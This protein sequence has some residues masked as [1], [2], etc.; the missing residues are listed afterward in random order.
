M[1]MN[2]W[3]GAMLASVI[4]VT[5]CQS[6]AERTQLNIV[7]AVPFN[8][9]NAEHIIV[10]TSRT[11]LHEEPL[12]GNREYLDQVYFTTALQMAQLAGDPQFM[13]MPITLTPEL[14]NGDAGG[15]FIALDTPWLVSKG[16]L[17]HEE[18]EVAVLSTNNL[19]NSHTSKTMDLAAYNRMIANAI[20]LAGI[21]NPEKTDKQ[22]QLEIGSLQ[23]RR[24]FYGYSDNVEQNLNELT[25]VIFGKRGMLDR[26]N[27][28]DYSGPNADTYHNTSRLAFFLPRDKAQAQTMLNKIYTIVFMPDA[29]FE[30]KKTGQLVVLA[31]GREGSLL[32]ENGQR[33]AGIANPSYFYHDDM[34]NKERDLPHF[35][36]ERMIDYVRSDTQDAPYKLRN[37]K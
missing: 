29:V 8:R 19:W 2:S 4:G 27:P 16:A 9:L 32:D 12:Q 31:N 24:F 36:C 18:M 35:T 28:N 15:F 14:Y 22:Q 6:T 5:G 26:L 30:I 34:L 20:A 17:N 23:P 7:N 21:A 3:K 10:T 11:D 33:V 37:C 25:S 1:K 13:S